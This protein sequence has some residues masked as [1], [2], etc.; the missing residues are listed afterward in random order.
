MKRSSNW[1]RLAALASVA[2]SGS[3]IAAPDPLTPLDF[4]I[5]HWTAPPPSDK[6]APNRGGTSEIGRDL[7]GTVLVRR[8]RT[9]LKGGG[10][11]EMLMVIYPDRSG[12]RADFFDSE[13]HVIHYAQSDLQ[14]GKSVQFTSESPPEAPAFRLTYESRQ[15]SGLE[16]RFEIAPP[17]PQRNFKTY[18][19]GA[20]DRQ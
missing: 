12:L 7:G 18:A 20:L 4:L 17:G 14:P 9:L 3:A 10:A 5:G 11:I 8:D 19:E 1:L 13:H 6:D 15:G 2:F 16:V